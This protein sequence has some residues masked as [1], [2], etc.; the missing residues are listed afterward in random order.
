MQI[1]HLGMYLKTE[2]NEIR[3]VISIR[4]SLFFGSFLGRRSWHRKLSKYVGDV[5]PDVWAHIEI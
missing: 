3:D 5:R 4:Y 2:R 1:I